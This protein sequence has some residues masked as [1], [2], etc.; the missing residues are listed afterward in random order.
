MRPNT[1]NPH[2]ARVVRS[3][4]AT[5][6]IS[7]IVWL[8]T[9]A[10]AAVVDSLIAAANQTSCRAHNLQAA[11][12]AA[13]SAYDLLNGLPRGPHYAIVYV[14]AA[15]HTLDAVGLVQARNGLARRVLCRH[16]VLLVDGLQPPLFRAW[17]APGAFELI[18]SVRFA[19][20]TV[21]MMVHRGSSSSSVSWAELPQIMTPGETAICAGNEV[22][23]SVD[24]SPPDV[25]S[26][27]VGSAGRRSGTAGRLG[28]AAFGRDV[29]LFRLLADRMRSQMLMYSGVTYLFSHAHR[30]FNL[31]TFE[32]SVT[33]IGPRWLQAFLVDRELRVGFVQLCW[34]YP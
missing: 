23:V 25:M 21:E 7:T 34:V 4:I 22:I 29:A 20:N 18:V 6:R 10:S 17:F 19:T 26:M 5:L 12:S 14:V 2:L 3:L 16:I 33:G 15:W 11:A 9:D 28:P 1:T 31:Q 32:L 8:Y 13:P 24:M 30:A 27:R